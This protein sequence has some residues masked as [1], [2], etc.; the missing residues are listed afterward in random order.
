M[1]QELTSTMC[2]AYQYF[3]KKY[4]HTYFSTNLIRIESILKILF[5]QKDIKSLKLNKLYF[6]NFLQVFFYWK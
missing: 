5:R 6:F 3:F 1:L 4:I 2:L